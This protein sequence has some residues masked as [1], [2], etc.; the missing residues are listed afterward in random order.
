MSDVFGV[1]RPSMRDV[2]DENRPSMREFYYI[3]DKI[4]GK[5]FKSENKHS[6][7]K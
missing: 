3:C 2:F 6:I 1:F 5:D 4:L 7:Y